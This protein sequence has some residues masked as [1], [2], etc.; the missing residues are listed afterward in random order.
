MHLKLLPILLLCLS[1]FVLADTLSYE[2]LVRLRSQATPNIFKIRAS[3]CAHG[4]EMALT[5]FLAREH[6]GIV[7]ALHGVDGCQNIVALNHQ[8]VWTNLEVIAVDR[9][10]DAA[11]LRSESIENHY[12]GYA[13]AGFTFSENTSGAIISLGYPFDLTELIDEEI[14]LRSDS[15]GTSISSPLRNLIPATNQDAFRNCDSPDITLDVLNV[16]APLRPGESGAPLLNN[17]N[18]VVAIVMGGLY[19]G[20]IDIAWATQVMRLDFVPATNIST[21]TQGCLR[22]RFAQLT[23]EVEPLDTIQSDIANFE[24]IL[25]GIIERDPKFLE[26]DYQARQEYFAFLKATLYNLRL[27]DKGFFEAARNALL[28]NDIANFK[29]LIDDYVVRLVEEAEELAGIAEAIQGQLKGIA[30]Q[31]FD[32]AI[33]I[34][35][36]SPQ[37][38]LEYLQ[39]AHRLDGQNIQT[40][41]ELGI[42]QQRL[43]QQ[44]K[45]LAA[46]DKILVILGANE[47]D[48]I[49][50]GEALGNIGGIYL[51]MGDYELALIYNLQAFYIHKELGNGLGAGKTLNNIGGIYEDVGKYEMALNHYQQAF[52]IALEIG[53]IA[54]Q[55]RALNNIG[56]IWQIKGEYALALDYYQKSLVVRHDINDSLGEGKLLNNIGVIYQSFKG[57]YDMALDYYERALTIN[58][59]VGDRSGEGRTLNNIATA[60]ADKGN[61]NRA[62]ERYEQALYIAHETNDFMHEESILNNIGHIY[63]S[64]GEDDLALEYYQKA[65]IIA[66]G[67]PLA[68]GRILNNIGAVYASKTDY[69]L[70]LEYYE[71]ALDISGEIDNSI[72]QS[73][74][75]NNI[76]QVYYNRKEY[77][78]ALEFIGKALAIAEKLAIPKDIKSYQATINAI[79][80]KIQ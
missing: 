68:L 50:K 10:R 4:G 74:I 79:R 33:V 66:N 14:R 42:L 61:Y 20:R 23:G 57:D 44:D 80:S 26:Q 72:L 76:G 32:L 29:K 28:A 1:S 65:L 19:E 64:N 16:D 41:N 69:N 73:R 54:G 39:E 12:R 30:Q 3:N 62:L 2:E 47:G 24:R 27:R 37:K 38:S 58:Q 78:Q 56:A 77:W 11:L 49:Y 51:F 46:F 36:L 71:Q 18:E 8:E 21:D 75:L 7:T 53:D 52:Y 34:T 70:A 45:A 15:T 25:H 43:G 13:N 67:R 63:Q 22:N 48:H 60:Y 40:L 9:G 59:Q 31:Y 5:G 6:Q 35:Y 17:N 55:A